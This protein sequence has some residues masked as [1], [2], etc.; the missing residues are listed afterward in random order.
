MNIPLYRYFVTTIFQILLYSFVKRLS[1]FKTFLNGLVKLL[2]TSQSLLIT[3]YLLL[4]ARLNDIVGNN[5][6]I[7]VRAFK[8]VYHSQINK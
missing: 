6:Y 8:L 3:F 2:V 1:N 4:F 5:I 7:I